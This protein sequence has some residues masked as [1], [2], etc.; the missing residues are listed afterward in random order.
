MAK[1]VLMILGILLL[2]ASAYFGLLKFRD[3][4]SGT[5]ANEQRTQEVEPETSDEAP[6]EADTPQAEAPAEF[7]KT[8]YGLSTPAS[9][10]WVVNK[11]RPLP[12][13]YVPADLVAA[14]VRLRL[15]S[16]SER[17][18]FSQ[19]ASADLKKLFDGAA[20]AGHVLVFA[21]GY[22]SEATQRQLYNSYVANDGQAAADRYSA[23]PGTSEHQTGLAFDATT[24]SE[25]CFLEVCFGT[26]PEGAWLLAN[27]HRYGFIVR[28]PQGKESVTGYQYEPW[29]LRWVGV[30]LATEM[31]RTGIT[32]LEEFFGLPAAPTYL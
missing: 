22:R 24:P 12:A 27:A 3:V 16:S 2:V 7:D 5:P 18:K 1:K 10:W 13:G 11:T 30:E 26:T 31:K 20:A 9:P 15:A 17:M 4:F 25:A 29:H 19:A 14:P 23:R 32:T 21:S 8:K 28:Y 6:E